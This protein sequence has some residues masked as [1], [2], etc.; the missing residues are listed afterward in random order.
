MRLNKTPS[1]APDPESLSK[2]MHTHNNIV[3]LER[4]TPKMVEQMEKGTGNSSPIADI[5][6]SLEVRKY[7]HNQ[8]SNVRIFARLTDLQ[9]KYL[10]ENINS[11]QIWLEKA[12]TMSNTTIRKKGWAHPANRIMPEFK[13]S[14]MTEY[15]AK[16]PLFTDKFV[17]HHAYGLGFGNYSYRSNYMDSVSQQLSRSETGGVVPTEYKLA[18]KNIVT[19]KDNAKALIFDLHGKH[20]TDNLALYLNIGTPGQRVRMVGNKNFKHTDRVGS[21]NGSPH[22]I[23]PNRRLFFKF[24]LVENLDGKKTNGRLTGETLSAVLLKN[25]NHWLGPTSIGLSVR[26]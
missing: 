26:S 5:D 12:G 14:D 8:E 25:N 21:Y 13:Q 16:T 23:L 17:N 15:V 7:T 9:A 2:Q 18:A 24:R 10:L 3:D 6:L 22:Q 11:I 20:F 4:I 19:L 1:F